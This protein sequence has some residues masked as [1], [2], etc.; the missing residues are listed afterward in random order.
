MFL[1]TKILRSWF[2]FVAA[3]CLSL[4]AQSAFSQSNLP[5]DVQADLLKNQIV[6]QFKRNDAEGA[7]NSI[8]RYKRIG[9]T[10]PPVLYFYEAKAATTTKEYLRA[11][12]AMEQYFKE[13]HDDSH[14]AEAL[15]LYPQIQETANQEMTVIVR[16]V[17]G[18]LQ[19]VNI[20]G[21]AFMMGN[22]AVNFESPSHR[23]TV[24][25]FGLMK[26]EVTFDQ[27]DIFAKSTGRALPDD[28][29]WGRANRPVIN[30]SWNDA[31]AF[32]QWLSTDN[33]KLRLPT[34]GEWE[35]AA[36][37]GATTIYPWGDDIGHGNA[38][39]RD[40]DSQWGGKMTAPV[41]SFAPNAFGIHDMNGNVREWVQDCHH[42]G[43][44]GAPSDGGAWVT[45]CYYK[46]N[47]M[48]RG[49]AWDTPAEYIRSD[50]HLENRETT[51]RD[52]RSGF[53]LAQDSNE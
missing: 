52:T 24:R 11:K 28:N 35:Y 13:E 22:A 3:F 8:E 36:R 2:I 6:D 30:V 31:Q 47:R 19:L 44:D 10:V 41:G 21:G 33:R 38:N 45:A 48:L 46:E 50:R 43:Y 14:Y 34:E 23:V 1:K 39:C 51:Y 49:G 9:V 32:A 15:K 17:A 5:P 4:A 16:S 7:L 20:P 12:T 40:C 29:G 27:Y 18:T 25:G 26:Y 37:A 42:L 53:R